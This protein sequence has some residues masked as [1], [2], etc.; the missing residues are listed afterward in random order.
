MFARLYQCIGR[1][2]SGSSN[3]PAHDAYFASASDLAELERRM[4]QV[5][6]DDH[7]YRLSY[8]CARP[9]ERHVPSSNF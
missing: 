4:R 7:A 6:E 3:Q 1:L 5:D 2:L 8:C 9:R